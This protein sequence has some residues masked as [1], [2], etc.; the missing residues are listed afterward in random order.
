M[1]FDVLQHDGTEL[2]T[3]P[4]HERRRILEDLFDTHELSAPWTLCQTTTDLAM[5]R[6]RLETRT[7][8]GSW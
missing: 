4:C 3:R 2:L 8:R 5:A 7:R 1:A 6:E